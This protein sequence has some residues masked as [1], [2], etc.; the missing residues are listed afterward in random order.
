VIVDT[1]AIVAILK[2]EPGYEAYELALARSQKTVISAA[3][4][5]EASIVLDLERDPILARRF[6]EL[7]RSSETIIEP[8]S[9]EQPRIAREAYRDFG[10]RSGSSAKLNF[11][12]CFAYAL[13]KD[14]D[15]SLLFKGNDF[16][17][18]D[19]R[20]ALKDVQT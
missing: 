11:G 7:L 13:A 4:W 18:T 1:S 17:H 20:S 19:I 5:V 9:A 14:R 6:E 15:M 16:G 12:D 2:R 10:K 8:V 3:T